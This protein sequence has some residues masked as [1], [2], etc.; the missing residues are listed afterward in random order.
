MK[1]KLPMGIRGKEVNAVYLTLVP[2]F[3][4]VCCILHPIYEKSSHSYCRSAG[5]S[6]RMYLL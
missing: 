1:C 2:F 6:D 5:L 3:L 4:S